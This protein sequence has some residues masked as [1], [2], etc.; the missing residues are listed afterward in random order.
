MVLRYSIG[1]LIAVCLFF[2]C[3]QE[4]AVY[5]IV[6]GDT[7]G[8]YFRVTYQNVPQLSKTFIKSEIDSI[9]FVINDEM[10]TYIDSSFISVFNKSPDSTISIPL[11]FKNVLEASKEIHRFSKGSFD[12]TVMPLANYWGF[13]YTGKVARERWDTTEINSILDYVGFDKVYIQNGNLIKADPRAQL[14]LSAVAKGYAADVIADELADLGIANL[15]VDIGGDGFAKGKNK[16]GNN[17]TLGIN[18]PDPK[19]NY[20]DIYILLQVD[21]KGLATS[22]N[23]RNYYEVDGE[24]YGHTINAKTGFPYKSNVLSA[25]VIAS[26]AMEADALATACMATN[27]ESGVGMIEQLPGVEA[28]LIYEDDAGNMKQKYTAGFKDYILE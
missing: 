4:E 26:T 22:G 20:S 28:Y 9:L 15:L 8:T 23:Y 5:E 7:M 2:A 12:P 1:L 6:Q 19:A 17:W 27:L 24:L 21:N 16:T 14:D 3:K 13:G 25:S 11:H 18:T 10:S